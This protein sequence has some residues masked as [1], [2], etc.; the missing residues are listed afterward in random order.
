MS[1]DPFAFLEAAV[2]EV[3]RRWNLAAQVAGQDLAA[4][5]K[6]GVSYYERGLPD[7]THLAIVRLFAPIARR[8]EV[9]LGSVLLN[10]YLSKAVI[11]AV[12]QHALGS[13]ELLANDLE[14]YY[15]LYHR[16]APLELLAAHVQDEVMEHLKD[17]YFGDEDPGRGIYGAWQRM[18]S[19]TRSQ[20]EP[21]PVYAVPAFL[22]R[23]LELAIRRQLETLLSDDALREHLGTITASLAFFY[24]QKNRVTSDTQSSPLFFFRLIEQYHLLTRKQVGDAFGLK[25]D[26]LSKERI[27]AALLALERNNGHDITTEVAAGLRSL[28]GGLLATF[29]KDIDQGGETWLLGFIRADHKLIEVSQGVFFGAMTAQVTLGYLALSEGPTTRATIGCRLCGKGVPIVLQKYVVSG[30][31]AFRFHTKNPQL[32]K[33]ARVLCIKCALAAYLQMRVLGAEEVRVGGNLRQVPQR[34]TLA[35]HYGPHDD[36]DAKQFAY[37][38]DE[39]FK[40]IAVLGQQTRKEDYPFSVDSVRKLVALRAASRAAAGVQLSMAQFWKDVGA[41]DVAQSGIDVLGNISAQARVLPLGTGHFR[42]LAFVFPQLQRRGS[43]NEDV[44]RERFSQS[45]LAAYTMLA[46]LRKLCG[47]D[48]P[49]YFQSVPQLRPGE[50]DPHSFYVRGQRIG[51]DRVLRHYGAIINFARRIAKPR[52]RSRSVDWI[53]LAERIE[54]APF[55]MCAEILRRTP[56]RSRDFRPGVPDTFD[57]EPL[58]G[59]DTIDGTGVTDGRAYLTLLDQ[60]RRTIAYA[61]TGSTKR[62]ETMARRVDTQPLAEFCLVLFRALDD[63]GGVGIDFLPLFLD[64]SPNAYER[65]SRLL[66]SSIRIHDDVE[67]GYEEWS[68]KILRTAQEQR[69]KE[70]FPSLLSVR[71]WLVE[72]RELF[73]QRRDNLTHL[74][75]S[76]LCLVYEYLYP[77]RRLVIKYTEASRGNKPA[78]EEEAIRERFESVVADERAKLAE[79]YGEGEQLQTILADALL[80]LI[81]NRRAL[82]WKEKGEEK[83]PPGTSSTNGA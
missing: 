40:L 58:A 28:F 9:F 41:D 18:S 77:R 62:G 59:P 36:Q 39:I 38:I 52:K 27:R 64:A 34:Y 48:G 21:F 43:K 25:E 80:F 32:G 44:V 17:L 71:R 2:D 5:I 82:R 11:R 61:H 51:V 79:V 65:Y 23:N 76:L 4:R 55:E 6:D 83:E 14:S 49:Y 53:L 24:G 60:I 15:F 13:I 50:F 74:K 72:H 67:A 42:L 8:E 75:R 57:Y 19:F 69:R 3:L 45:R 16:L 1:A 37:K 66:L 35:F 10:D 26:E 54:A 7:G 20:Y 70:Q 81:L 63:I 56:M 73:E 29:G 68:T 78:M 46:L 31:G 47:C 22:A 30:L 33:E 12:E